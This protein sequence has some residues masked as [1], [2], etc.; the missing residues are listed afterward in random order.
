MTTLRQLRFLVALSD[1]LNFSRAAERCHVTQPTLS[2]GLK[3]LE[4][5]LGVPL[6][7]RSKRS[8]MLTPVGAEV[9][10]RARVVLN[11]VADIEA[12][13][14]AQAGTLQGDLRLGAIPTVGP[15]LVPRALG[16]LRKAW[17]DQ[18]LFL[19]EELTDSLLAGLAEGRLDLVV[20]ALPHAVGSIETELLFEDGYQ[21]ATSIGHALAGSAEVTGAKLAESSILLLEK[22]HCLQ[23]HALEA[24]AEMGA[25]PGDAFS[26]T[27]LP[28][29]ISM[30]EE[31]LGITLLP[32]LAVDAGIARGH[33]IILTPLPGACP[34][35]VV[36]GW[37][38]TSPHA[39][40][41]REIAGIFRQARASLR[42]TM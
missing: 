15:F 38:A 28:T 27:S 1:T 24:Y 6:A 39:R 18:R 40:R 22:G 13:A 23:R 5:Q 7:E 29:L 17:P 9:V 3:E 32:Q 26:A 37:R 19:R 42:A 20:L 11:D 31:G 16:L 33:S 41:F 25:P 34:R 36:L 2:A 21:L 4:D 12:L 35:R 8:V 30:V 14:H 10:R